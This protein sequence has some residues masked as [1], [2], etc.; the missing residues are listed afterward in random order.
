[1]K[2]EFSGLQPNS[3]DAIKRLS[4]IRKWFQSRTELQQLTL[5]GNIMTEEILSLPTRDSEVFNNFVDV[6]SLL[7]NQLTDFDISHFGI[8]NT[9]EHSK[10][11]IAD[12]VVARHALILQKLS[13]TFDAIG[14]GLRQI[15]IKDQH[16]KLIY[17]GLIT[18][19]IRSLDCSADALSPYYS[20]FINVISAGHMLCGLKTPQRESNII[21]F[22]Y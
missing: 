3:L 6:S 20:K 8:D 1:M 16:W 17:Q 7:F 5:S 9:T 19:Y 4:A 11:I 22:C 10:K 21:V 18:S 13:S 14:N 12:Y 2:T 15:G